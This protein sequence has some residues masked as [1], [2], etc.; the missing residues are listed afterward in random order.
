MALLILLA[1]SPGWLEVEVR[2]DRLSK[3]LPSYLRPLRLLSLQLVSP[4]VNISDELG[5]SDLAISDLLS[6]GH[7]DPPATCC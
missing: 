7:A 6:E 3:C 1:L 4:I 5:E 2:W